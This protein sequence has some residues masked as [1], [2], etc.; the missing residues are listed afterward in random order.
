MSSI[1]KVKKL[2][3]EGMEWCSQSH[4]AKKI[5]E[6]GFKVSLVWLKILCALH[7]DGATFSLKLHPF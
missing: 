6:I 1:V 3:L 7:S 2:S 5:A 4:V